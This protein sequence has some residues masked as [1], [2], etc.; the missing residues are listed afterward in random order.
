MEQ[1]ILYKNLVEGVVSALDLIYNEQYYADKIVEKTLKSNKKWGGRD[2]RFIAE[3]IY[4]C[5]RWKRLYDEIAETNNHFS[6]SNIWKI[7]GVYVVINEFQ[8]PAWNEFEGL[9]KELIFQKYKSFQQVRAIRESIPDW[10]DELGIE[11]LQDQ[12]DSEIHALNQKAEV[13]LRVNTLKVSVEE[14]QTQLEN[15]GIHTEL[16]I[17]YPD[18]LQLKNRA[19]IFR[20]LAFKN[21]LFEM[22]DASSQLVAP[23][24][25]VSPGMRVVDACAGA[26]GKTLHLA[27]L[28]EN[29]GQLIALDI[30][31]QKLEDLRKRAKRNSVYN[32]ETRF[33]SSS[34]TIKKLKNSADRLLIDAPCSGLGVIRRNPDAKWKL[35]KNQIEQIKVTQKELLDQYCDILKTGGKMVYATC[36]ILP[37]ENEKQVTSFLEKHLE[38]KLLKELKVSPSKSGFDGF[39]MA[40]IEKIV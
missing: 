38:F 2:R 31:E 3:A 12:W 9:N 30:Y 13:I 29:K 7:V 23:F 22:Q 1:K 19:N 35:N 21:G 34:K 27:S 14:L 8:I 6:I 26:G 11:E 39:Y 18:A 17:H 20:T 40:L 24:L 10:L 36:S 15:E 28:M 4:E 32:I 5:V 37:S 16:L 25:E 33:I